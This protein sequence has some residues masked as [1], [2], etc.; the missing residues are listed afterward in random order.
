MAPQRL[1]R[2]A[3]TPN[4][5]K[6]TVVGVGHADKEQIRAMIGVLLPRA[7]VRSED[8]ADALAVAV[9]HANMRSRGALEAAG[10]SDPAGP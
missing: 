10:V 8:A 3:A 6:K 9:C 1:P 2:Y 5:V 4:R 7:T